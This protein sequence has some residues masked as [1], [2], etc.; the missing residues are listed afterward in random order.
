MV[1]LYHDDDERLS[2]VLTLRHAG[3]R[4]HSGQVSFPG[5]RQ[6]RQDNDLTDTAIRETGEEIG[7]CGEKISVLGELPRFYIPA[8]HYDV[9]PTVAYCAT[10]PR[11]RPNPDEVAQIFSFALEDLLHPR[12]KREERRVIQGY[13]VWVPYYDVGGHKVWGATAIMLGEFEARLRRV[14]P[15]RVLQGLG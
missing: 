5:G 11:F 12:F 9:Y 14:L 15:Q 2:V 13:D 8:S 1:L 7:I 4:G 6:D 3:L 10:L